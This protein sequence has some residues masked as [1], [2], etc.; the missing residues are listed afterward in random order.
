MEV[1]NTSTKN[2][3]IKGWLLV[4]SLV[5][6]VYAYT[7]GVR[8]LRNFSPYMAILTVNLEPVYGIL[9]AVLVFGDAE[10]MTPGFYMGTLVI[11]VAVV[12]YPFWNSRLTKSNPQ[13]P[14]PL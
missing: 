1:T 12:A 9:L 6:T 7:V 13:Q 11:L 2:T 4:L 8:L 3:P 5:C 14:A 10:R